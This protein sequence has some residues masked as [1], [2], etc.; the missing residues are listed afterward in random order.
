MGH[1]RTA[2]TSKPKGL[3]W[4]ALNLVIED[5]LAGLSLQGNLNISFEDHPL[6]P[7]K[8]RVASK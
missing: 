3:P 5:T 8:V 1:R 2:V 4:F 6:K 7:K